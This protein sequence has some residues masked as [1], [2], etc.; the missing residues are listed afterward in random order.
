[1][2][3]TAVDGLHHRY[4]PYIGSGQTIHFFRCAGAMYESHLAQRGIRP[5]PTIRLCHGIPFSRLIT[6]LL[7]AGGTY[8]MAGSS[9]QS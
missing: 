3:I 2:H 8:T 4:V 7:F 6:I 5:L 9:M 1:M